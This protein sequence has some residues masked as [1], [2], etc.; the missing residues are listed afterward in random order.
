MRDLCVSMSIVAWTSEMRCDCW[1]DVH[2]PICA[3]VH[4]CRVDLEM[5]R[6]VHCVDS[7]IAAAEGEDVAVGTGEVGVAVHL[8]MCMYMCMCMCIYMHVAT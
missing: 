3:Y 2:V 1:L 8:G 7:A 5:T 6:G 4:A